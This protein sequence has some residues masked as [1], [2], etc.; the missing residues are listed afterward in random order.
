MRVYRTEQGT[1][2]PRM[3]GNGDISIAFIANGNKHRSVLSQRGGRQE[4]T[5]SGKHT[6]RRMRRAALRICRQCQDLTNNDTTRRI[7]KK[8]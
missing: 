3:E 2:H 5:F 6:P 1:L 8:L 7:D 4:W